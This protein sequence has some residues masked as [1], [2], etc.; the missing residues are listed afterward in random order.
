MRI[1]KV[2]ILSVG[3]LKE[4]VHDGAKLY[5]ANEFDLKDE[6]YFAS[7]WIT[8]KGDDDYPRK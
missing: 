7:D 3:T 4:Y 1:S 2:T 6:Q 8:S 5:M